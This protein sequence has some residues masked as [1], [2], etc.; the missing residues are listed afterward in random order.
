MRLRDAPMAQLDERFVGPLEGETI[1]SIIRDALLEPGKPDSTL[2]P[3]PYICSGRRRCSPRASK[4]PTG[5]GSKT[6]SADGG[7]LAARKAL[8]SMTPEQV[9]DEV[10]KAKLR[11]L[12]GAGFPTGKKVVVHPEANRQTKVSGRQRGR[13]RARDLQGPLHP[14]ARP[15]RAARRHPHRRLCHRQS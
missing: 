8:T 10:S 13:G 1:D 11:G 6:T 5:R 9:T 2:E 4:I 15:A 3:E 7:Y 14:G 12:G